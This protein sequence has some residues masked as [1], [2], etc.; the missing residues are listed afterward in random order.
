MYIP[1][2]RRNT[3]NSIMFAVP[4]W[5]VAS[6]ALKRQ[7]VEPKPAKENKKSEDAIE[8]VSK[9]SKKSEG[10]AEDAT[11]SS[12][13]RKRGDKGKGS[14]VNSTN[15]AELYESIIEGKTKDKSK[16]AG[17]KRQ[18]VS[19]EG[20]EDGE[21][22]PVKVKGEKKEKVKKEKGN[23]MKDKK[24]EKKA[25]KAAEEASTDDTPSSTKEKSKT[26]DTPKPTQTKTPIPAPKLTPLQASMRQK[27]ISA[28]FRHLNQTLY[29]TPSSNSLDLFSTNPEMFTEYHEG[30][31]RQVEVWPENPVDIYIRSILA[32]GALKKPSEGG[33][34]MPLP[35]TSGTCTIADLGCGDAALAST[36]QKDSKKL[37]LKI[38]SFDLYSPHPLV[39]RA[40]IADVPLP[41]SS[42]DIAIFC[43]ALMGTNWID[44][45]E[46]AF[47]ILRWKGELWIAEI[48][49]RFSRS[50]SKGGVVSHSVGHRQK[51]PS[52]SISKKEKSALSLQTEKNND[53]ALAVEVDDNPDAVRSETDLHA[54]I[55][56]LRKRG[57]NLKGPETG[58]KPVDMGNKMFSDIFSDAA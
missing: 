9:S 23:T 28:R 35:R 41:D 42:V 8:D 46:E 19:T 43:L 53:L 1:H 33:A 55:E 32:R 3:T 20:G 5:S 14:E 49:S 12:K 39:T 58:E 45:I 26:K 36:L 48:K 16:E 40:D 44:F 13:K 18:K 30:F 54:F 57:F 17:E 52:S 56:V 38:H 51:A 22:V 2:R 7:T 27:L 31:R 34:I 15:V 21:D 11:K 29:T 50:N 4:G 25:R 47:R 6:T 37:H 24:R 10:T